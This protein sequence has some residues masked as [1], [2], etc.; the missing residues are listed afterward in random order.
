MGPPPTVVERAVTLCR[1]GEARSWPDLRR[2]LAAEGF[3][4][5][6]PMLSQHADRLLD[7]M[8][9][10]A[11]DSRISGHGIPQFPFSCTDTLTWEGADGR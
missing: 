1:N 7:A 3:N 10:A 4:P 11:R 2:R 9:R 5:D 6:H 8:K